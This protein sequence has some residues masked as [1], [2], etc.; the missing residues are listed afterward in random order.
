MPSEAKQSGRI[1]EIVNF[2]ITPMMQIMV[3]SLKDNPSTL[4]RY[5]TYGYETYNILI[6]LLDTIVIVGVIVGGA[7]VLGNMMLNR[8][9]PGK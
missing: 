4:Y 6:D 3:K 1:F 7:F 2:E 8:S 5:Y 9:S